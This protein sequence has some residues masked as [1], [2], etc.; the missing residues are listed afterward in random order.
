MPSGKAVRP[1][2]NGSVEEL[3]HEIGKPAFLLSAMT[4]P[5]S[6]E[7]LAAVR[8]SRAIGVIYRQATERQSHYFHVRPAEQFDATIHIDKTRALEPL[9]LTSLWTASETPETYPTG[10]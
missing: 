9:E 3:F 10:L 2:L 5:A 8:L 1:A 4:S 7:P 6:E